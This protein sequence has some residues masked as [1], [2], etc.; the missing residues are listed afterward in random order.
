MIDFDSAGARDFPTTSAHW[1]TSGAENLAPKEWQ[2]ALK[3]FPMMRPNEWNEAHGL[4]FSVWGEVH[5]WNSDRSIAESRPLSDAS[6]RWMR[7][8]VSYF[9]DGA[10]LTLCRLDSNGI[11]YENGIDRL[12][13]TLSVDEEYPWIAQLQAVSTFGSHLL[14]S[15]INKNE[16]WVG[17]FRKTASRDGVTFG[18]ITDDLLGPRETG[19]DTVLRRG[20]TRNSIRNGREILRGYSW[21]T[22]LSA[23]LGERLGGVDALVRSEAFYKVSKLRGGAIF[24]QASESMAG[25]SDRTMERIFDVLRPVIPGGVPK[26]DPTVRKIPRIVWVDSRETLH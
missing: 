11:P 18:H 6:L 14:P 1:L 5:V 23:D 13:L 25:Y 3:S 21:V 26:I 19:L 20:G 9:P 22:V 7:N 12:D 17:F 10:R 15:A 2:A 16:L 4:P 8:E 24:L